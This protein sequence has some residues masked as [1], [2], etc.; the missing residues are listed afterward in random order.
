MRRFSDIGTESLSTSIFA[1]QSPTAS[2][3]FRASEL[4]DR[5]ESSLLELPERYR[6]VI[7]LRSFCD[8][9]HAEVA[10]TLGFDKEGT[11]RQAYARALQKLKELIE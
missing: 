7:V 6:E 1:G 5:I 3:I 4:E 9:S 10:E 11:A 2:Q 8:M